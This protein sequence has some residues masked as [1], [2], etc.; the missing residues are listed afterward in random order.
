MKSISRKLV[1]ILGLILLGISSNVFATVTFAPNAGNLGQATIGQP[2][3]SPLTINVTGNNIQAASFTFSGLPAGITASYTVVDANSG[4]ITIS[5]TPTPAARSSNNI[6]FSLTDADGTTTSG[7]FTLQITLEIMTVNLP[8][9]T[10]GQAYNQSLVARGGA[11]G[12][13]TWSLVGGMLPP[14]L[15]LSAAGVISGTPTTPGT[16]PFNVN[17]TDGVQNVQR[18]F[19]IVIAQAPIVPISNEGQ[20]CY[21]KNVTRNTSGEIIKTGNL[22]IKDLTTGTEKQITNY[23]SANGCILNPQFTSDGKQI[24]FTYASDGTNFSIYLTDVKT[25]LSDPSQG[26]ITVV[27]GNTKYATISPNF[28]GKTV[29]YLVYTLQRTDRTELWVYNYSTKTNSQLVSTSGMTIK[30]PVFLDNTTVAFIG[31]VNSIQNI[32]TVSV[33]GGSLARLTNNTSPS[34]RYGRLIS[35][36]RNPLITPSIL[37]YSKSTYISY[38][39]YTKFDVYAMQGN[40]EY[41]LTNTPD[42]DEYDPCFFGDGTTM[43]TLATSGQMFY[44]SNIIGSVDIWQVNYDLTGDS[45]ILKTQRTINAEAEGLPNW[46]PTTITII[47]EEWSNIT[48]NQTRY[49][50]ISND[51]VYRAN[52]DG[53]YAVQLTNTPTPK[54][55]CDLARNGGS[56]IFG[57]IA[58]GVEKVIKM[59]HDGTDAGLFASNSFDIKE[60][61]ISPDGRWVV[62]VKKEG[63]DQYDIYVKPIGGGTETVITNGDYVNIESPRF[64]PDMTKIVYSAFDG[65]QWDIYVVDVVVDNIQG[66]IN[67]STTRQV[68][69]TYDVNE[70]YPSFS[71]TGKKIIYVSNERDNRYQ[72][73]TMDVTGTDHELVVSGG[74]ADTFAYPIYGPVYDSMTGRDAISYIMNGQIYYAFVYRNSLRNPIYSPGNNPA[75]DITPTGIMTNNKFGWGLI[76]QKGTVVGKR[77]FPNRASGSFAYEIIIDVDEASVP[78]GYIVNEI[79]PLGF[80]I[81]SIVREGNQ[82]V[83]STS[84]S[85]TPS[86]GLKTIKMSFINDTRSGAPLINGG[87]KDHVIR[88]TV[89]TGQLTGTQT[90]SGEINF[91]LEGVDITEVITGD[92]TIEITEPY[93]PIDITDPYDLDGDGVLDEPN[94]YV[95]DFDLLYAIDCWAKDA[96]LPGYGPK[97]PSNTDN[98]DLIIL[99]IIDIWADGTNKGRYVYDPTNPNAAH[100]MYW[101]KP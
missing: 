78:N 50:Y 25:T 13:Y 9:G 85:N 11:P 64:N 46:G 94:W 12:P 62:Y 60:A 33:G 44:A 81:S 23:T 80:N 66:T 36:I 38:G 57:E 63:V 61:S 70:R 82:P 99:D 31:V 17:V 75:A 41:N 3:V 30:D 18:A 90:I 48:I 39:Q 29:G 72:I 10:V 34:P 4:T 73:Y 49:V 52:Y 1:W 55:T 101:K 69:T 95:D 76:R 71:N 22:F 67:P 20:I 98:W 87:A 53:L 37:L 7:L 28:D 15:S 92:G 51:Q 65:I 59:N 91:S 43:P 45:N 16:Y 88:I 27:S 14:G 96:Q 56:I 42:I 97:W 19:S 79:V 54:T 58:G 24:L 74:P 2:F 100:E 32:Y 21:V 93:L 35:S 8:G 26:K 68:T 40:V 47:P 6:Q 77:Y 5:G 86:P 89:D 83:D 84:Y